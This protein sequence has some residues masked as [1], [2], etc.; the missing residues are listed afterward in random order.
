MQPFRLLGIALACASLAACEEKAEV[1][2]PPQQVRAVA[3]ALGQYQPG[4]EI[5][6]EVKA[7]IQTE[8]SFRVSGRVIERRAD[9]GSRVRAGEVLARLNDTEQ[10]ADLSVARAALESAKAVLTQKTLAFARS[11]S[12]IQSQAIAKQAF[13]SAQEELL[14]AQ[15]ALESAEAA[16]ATA[17]DALSY[18]ELKADA[19][20]I[21]TARTIEVGQVVSAAQSAFTLADDGPRDAVFDVFEAF[22]LNGPPLADVDVAPVGDQPDKVAAKIREVSPVIDTKAGTIRIKVALQDGTKWPLGTPVVGEIHSSPRQGIVLPYNAITSADGEPAVWL[23]NTEKHTVS[24]CKISVDR[25]RKSDFVVT[26][27]IAP[28]DLI[29]TEGG[30]FLREGQAVAWD[31]QV[32]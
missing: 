4:A 29:V 11:K 12:L 2:P 6:G 17:K 15:A 21:I 26:G 20:G 3:A 25:Y 24:L 8:L 30:K 22:F 7:R 5:T 23:V 10:Q 19:D 31:R 9:V 1:A 16:L 27:G 32:R 18:T 14:S 13:D 28:K